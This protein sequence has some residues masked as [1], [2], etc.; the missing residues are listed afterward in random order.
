VVAAAGV[1]ALG[2]LK[3]L[4]VWRSPLAVPLAVAGYGLLH[5]GFALVILMTSEKSSAGVGSFLTVLKF[6][7]I[8]VLLILQARAPKGASPPSQPPQ[9][10]GPA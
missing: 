1:T 6:I 2:W 10:A 7:G 8:V 4:P 9:P 5:A 3:A